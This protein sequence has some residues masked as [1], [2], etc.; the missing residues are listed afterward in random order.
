MRK[1]RFTVF[2]VWCILI[3]MLTACGKA[4]NIG[5]VSQAEKTGNTSGNNETGKVNDTGGV[6]DNI[7]TARETGRD[8]TDSILYT[9]PPALELRNVTDDN[10]VISIM[11]CG[12]NWTY[13]ESEEQA[14]SAIADSADPLAEGAP[15][16]TLTIP[17]N[18]SSENDSDGSIQA[19]YTISFPVIPDEILVRAWDIA[20]RGKMISEC[21]VSESALYN[22]EE[23][24]DEDFSIVLRAGNIYEIYVG[25]KE[26]K[27]KESGFYGDVYYTF[28]T[29]ADIKT[30]TFG[31]AFTGHVDAIDGVTMVITD[32]TAE[33]AA[34]KFTNCTDME[35]T[36][37]DDYE[38]QALM[39]GEWHRVNYLIDNWAYN[40]IG[41]FIPASKETAAV[42]EWNVDWSVFHG[43]LPG[44]HYRITKS[45]S[46]EPANEKGECMDYCLGAEFDV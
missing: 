13:L 10:N 15:W 25:W 20:N 36:Y 31:E 40:A 26:E 17:D 16:E 34:V 27:A 41:Y 21:P 37:G 35:I 32:V 29:R 12:Y 46:V 45:V 5:D 42:R 4:D 3:F 11:A 18:D 28:I 38:L 2:I 9:E 7:D 6:A 19:S 43:R 8:G 39:D 30:A 1:K 33:G 24:M 22:G 44:G 23:I 14:V